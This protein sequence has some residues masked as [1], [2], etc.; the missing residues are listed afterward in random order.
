MPED[1]LDSVGGNALNDFGAGRDV[2]VVPGA[3][4]TTAVMP[5]VADEPDFMSLTHSSG[6][7]GPSY[8]APSIS[9]SSSSSSSS[10]AA[11]TTTVAPTTFAT[12]PI[13]IPGGA[14]NV[15]IGIGVGNT[16]TPSTATTTTAATATTVGGT[17][18]SL[19]SSGP[20]TP[21]VSN[22]LFSETYYPF[23]ASAPTTRDVEYW[24]SAA[25]ASARTPAQVSSP[26]HYYRSDVTMAEEVGEDGE[27]AAKWR[28]A[29]LVYGLRY[30][31]DP[32]EV[33]KL[34]FDFKDVRAKPVLSGRMIPTGVW[35]VAFD[36]E[37]SVK[38]ALRIAKT[39]YVRNR[40]IVAE[41]CPPPLKPLVLPP[42]SAA[43]TVA[44]AVVVP[45]HSSSSPTTIH[46]L[47]SSSSSVSPRPLSSLPF[48]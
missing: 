3:L 32:K 11:T 47:S 31:A 20:G 1:V 22:H 19:V 9:A 34:F 10:S 12:R 8:S 48:K 28:H 36:S 6:F 37:A 4:A 44:P 46:S 30:V 42:A 5:T 23:A 26:R 18:S 29:I 40:R 7:C 33:C 35:K 25:M 17:Y 13:M 45:A 15:G 16:I 39:L 41:K 14:V 38:R 21:L 24:R 43:A 2:G 27:E